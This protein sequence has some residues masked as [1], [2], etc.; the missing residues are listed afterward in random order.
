[1]YL[2][3]KVIIFLDYIG[4]DESTGL[5]TIKEMDRET[6]NSDFISLKII[7][8]EKEDVSSAIEQ[9]VIIV[10]KDENDNIP[11]FSITDI[12]VT[13]EEVST[14]TI[15]IENVT[16]KDPDTVSI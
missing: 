4:I 6:L 7:A 13:L 1:M 15:K 14:G 12:S 3:K 11:T 8:F 5:F 16:I 2:F 10:V 9:S